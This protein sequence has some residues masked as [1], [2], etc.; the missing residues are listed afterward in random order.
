MTCF[1]NRLPW[2]L[3]LLSEIITT[4]ATSPEVP[5]NVLG[6]VKTEYTREQ[7]EVVKTEILVTHF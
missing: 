2:E 7:A 4:P 1:K 6:L 3:G 5:F